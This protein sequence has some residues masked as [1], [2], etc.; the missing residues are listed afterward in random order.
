MSRG[1][2][3]NSPRNQLAE[4][5]RRRIALGELSGSLPGI[6]KLMAEYG[7][8]RTTVEG[9]LEELVHAGQVVSH[10]NRRPLEILRLGTGGAGEGT[11]IVHGDP[12]ER[13]TGDHRDILIALEAQLPSPVVRLSLA[14][15]EDRMEKIVARVLESPFRRV[16]VMDHDAGVADRLLAAGRIVVAAGTGGEPTQAPQ[17]AVSHEMLVRG[18]VRRAFEAGHRRVSFP[19]WRRL[20]D[21]AQNMRRW[22]A[23]EYESRGLPH[24]PD[25]DAP[26]VEGRDAESLHA[27]L[28]GLLRHTPPTALV[29][30]D[31]QQ[32]L[33]TVSVLGECGM[34]IPQDMSLV[35]LCSTPEWE[36]ATPTPAHF[37][38]PVAAMVAGV[39]RAL[40]TAE[41]GA[42]KKDTVIAPEWVPGR[43]LAAPRA[44]ARVS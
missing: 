41:R 22:I 40:K 3:L 26:V 14:C 12:M 30:S 34:R 19:L 29:A 7:A 18:A 42:E 27:T 21:V 2:N 38:F 36:A 16:V 33:G 31:F 11:L 1:F 24:S 10:G 4:E 35:C 39:S 28:R 20:P 43:S 5:I 17:V 44:K 37:R 9:A 6:R 13:R 32:W 8:T 15:G 25:F 23:A